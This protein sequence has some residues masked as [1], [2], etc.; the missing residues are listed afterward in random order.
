MLKE[1]IKQVDG[2]LIAATVPYP[3]IAHAVV[4]SPQCPWI[5]SSSLHLHQASRQ[6]TLRLPWCLTACD[7]APLRLLQ[8]TSSCTHLISAFQENHECPAN[9]PDY[10]NHKTALARDEANALGSCFYSP[11]AAPQHGKARHLPFKDAP[12]PPKIPEAAHVLVCNRTSAEE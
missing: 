7:L 11:E 2:R 4:E 5:L 12:G 1:L 3:G 10:G 6:C 9:V 8:H